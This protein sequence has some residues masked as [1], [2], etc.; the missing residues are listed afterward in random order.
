M[1]QLNTWQYFSVTVTPTGVATI[2]VNGVAVATDTNS[3]YV[4]NVVDRSTNYLGRSP[5]GNPLFQGQ[6][7]SLSV[8][9]RPLSATEVQT[10]QS[11]VYN[12]S[13]TGLVGYWTMN[14]TTNGVVF[15]RGPNYLNSDT[16]PNPTR[17]SSALSFN[18]T[19]DFAQLPSN[20]LANFTNGF[21]AG[22]WAYTSSVADGSQ[23]FS[24]GNGPNSD[25]IVLRRDG[26]SNNLRF[27]VLR[28]SSS[29]GITAPN[30]IQLNTWQYFSVTVTSTGVATIYVNGVAVA[31]ETNPGFVPNVVDR[32]TNYLGRSPWG[33]ALFQG[34]MNSLSV[35]NRTLTPA[36]VQ[37]APFTAYTGSESGMVTYLPLNSVTNG[38]IVN[39]SN[40]ALNGTAMKTEAQAQMDAL[41]VQLVNYVDGSQ[42]ITWV[43][44]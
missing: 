18:G 30:V 44:G 39:P 24:F 17:F 37:A 6:M 41:V 28:G 34:K 8:W 40:S 42:P 12:G 16:G 32:S 33:N 1:I 21:S 31:T 38:T 5:W 29:Q 26:T 25:N 9:N 27:A 7:N 11:T 20:G 2:Y 35:W 19:S 13:E 22:V 14:D 3:G 43:I 10:A 23:Y 15:D 36:E 4:P